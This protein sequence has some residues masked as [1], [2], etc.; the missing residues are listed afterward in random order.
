[1]LKQKL[2][3]IMPPLTTPFDQVGELD[4]AALQRNVQRYNETGLSGYVVLG[5]NGEAVHLS[6][7]ERFKTIQT[8]KQ[9]ATPAHKVIA[10]INELSL[11]AAVQSCKQARESGADAVLVVTPYFYKAAMKQDVL[12]GYFMEVADQSPLPVLVY[13]VPQNTGVIIEPATLARLAEHP[14]I[15]GVK[16]SSGNFGAI[17]DTIRLAEDFSVMCGNGGI[18]YPALSMGA[19][20]AVLAIACAAPRACVELYQAAA[21]GDH[22]RA[23][24]LQNRISPISQMVTAGL[25]VAGLKAAMDNAGY[26]GGTVRSPLVQLGPAESEK[27]ATAMRASGLF[28]RME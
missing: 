20:G 12:F 2:S 17:A 9:A 27:L 1:M 7:E 25:G 21:A 3:G 13:N 18:L 26:E 8:V 14:N 24:E 6:A 15:I 11:R 5:S 23:R 4:Y 16:D 28:S 19:A 10:G 22:A